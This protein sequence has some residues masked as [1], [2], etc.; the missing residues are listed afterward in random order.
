MRLKNPNSGGVALRVIICAVSLAILAGAI[1]S[2]MHTFQADKEDDHRRAVAL[3][4]YG[5]QKA[6]GEL[7]ISM[8]WA[9]GFADEHMDEEGGSFGVA[10]TREERDGTVYMKIVSTGTSGS[11]TQTRECTLRLSVSEDGD[12]TWVNEGI[13]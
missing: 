5:L 6:F 8:D 11:V 1:V 10:V 9:A 12:S 3:A 7:T 13:R 2:L 4:E